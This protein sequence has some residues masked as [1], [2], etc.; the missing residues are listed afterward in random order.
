MVGLIKAPPPFFPRLHPH[1]LRI[2]AGSSDE[3]SPM[4]ALRADMDGLPITEEVD[5]PYMSK[6]PGCMHACGHDAH[7]A[8]L[9]GAAR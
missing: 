4:I 2:S 8:M 7:M 1:R 9:L 5:V 3:N 6:T